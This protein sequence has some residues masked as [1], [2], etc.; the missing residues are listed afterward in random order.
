MPV[1]NIQG[2]SLSYITGS[3]ENPSQLCIFSDLFLARN[4]QQRQAM[5]GGHLTLADALSG[6]ALG[7]F[8]SFATS[9]TTLRVQMKA[10]GSASSKSRRR[11]L[12]KSI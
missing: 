4:L 3:L 1:F 2:H 10:Q 5:D 9:W 11:K 12:Y 6:A 7:D 8:T